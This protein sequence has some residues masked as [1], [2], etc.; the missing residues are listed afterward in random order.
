MLY[1]AGSQKVQLDELLAAYG[2]GNFPQNEFD[3]KNFDENNDDDN[4][5]YH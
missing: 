2:D 1:R 5:D 4:D 3:E